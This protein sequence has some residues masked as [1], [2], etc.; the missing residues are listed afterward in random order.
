MLRRKKKTWA[1][2]QKLAESGA[3]VRVGFGKDC[4]RRLAGEL[5]RTFSRRP[6]YTKD[7]GGR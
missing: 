2:E 6:D 7:K 1:E 5:W 4:T 3:R